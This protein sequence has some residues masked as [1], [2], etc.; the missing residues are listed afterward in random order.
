MNS[1]NIS[2]YLF[3]NFSTANL[4]TSYNSDYIVNKN[5]SDDIDDGSGD[6]DKYDDKGSRPCAECLTGSTSF[7]PHNPMRGA[8]ITLS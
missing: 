8:P 7:N 6:H 5:N 2:F 3:N 4:H 1:Q